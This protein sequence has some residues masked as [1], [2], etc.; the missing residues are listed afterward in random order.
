M[1]LSETFV[2]FAVGKWSQVTI[3]YPPIDGGQALAR[4]L[5][6]F[7]VRNEAASRAMC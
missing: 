2:S 5:G 6:G 1:K 4:Q 7:L 3:R